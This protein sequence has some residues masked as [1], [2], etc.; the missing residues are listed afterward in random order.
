MDVGVSTAVAAGATS[1][2]ET[3]VK[4]AEGGAETGEGLGRALNV[5]DRIG[6]GQTCGRVARE[7][8]V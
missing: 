8:G 1:S 4:G 5:E 7:V 3:S 6:G 2:E